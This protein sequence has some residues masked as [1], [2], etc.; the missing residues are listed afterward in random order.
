MA[1]TCQ[2]CARLAPCKA[3]GPLLVCDRCWQEGL[4]LPCGTGQHD[5]HGAEAGWV[6]F[7]CGNIVVASAPPVAAP[8]PT[9]PPSYDYDS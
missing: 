2:R 8:A 7:R 6:C 9:P 3:L 1:T 5:Y 4:T